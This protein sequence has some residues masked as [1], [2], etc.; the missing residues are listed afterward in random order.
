MLMWIYAPPVQAVHRLL[1]AARSAEVGSQSSSRLLP[2]V[3][4]HGIGDGDRLLLWREPTDSAATLRMVVCPAAEP[5]LNN[6]D[7]NPDPDVN[8]TP[9]PRPAADGAEDG[10][11]L[12]WPAKRPRSAAG[13]LTS[14]STGQTSPAPGEPADL[15]WDGYIESPCGPLLAGTLLLRNE[16]WRRPG[17]VVCEDGHYAMFMPA[18]PCAVM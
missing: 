3:E 16:C 1:G 11:P 8:P 2:Q 9:N 10:P 15:S 5:V 17:Q 14:P 4:L 6:E 7:S 13:S 12:S 18:A